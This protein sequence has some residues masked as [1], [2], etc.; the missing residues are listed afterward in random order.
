MPTTGRDSP[1]RPSIRETIAARRA[2]LR[3]TP[4]S[5]RTGDLQTYG[6]PAGRRAGTPRGFVYLDG[7]GVDQINDKSVAGQI[8][9][10]K[11]SGKLDIAGL[12]LDRIPAKVFTELLG[13]DPKGLSNPPPPPSPK[14]TLLAPKAR[15]ASASPFATEDDFQNDALKDDVFGK[16]VEKEEVWTE[17]EA[18]LTTFRAGH[19]Q[20]LTLDKEIGMFGGLKI[21]DLC[22]NGL[23]AIP[24]SLSDLLRL[25]SLDLS[26]NKLTSIPRS[27]L[28]LP[29]LQWLDLSSNSIASLSF[30]S[31]IGPSEDGLGYGQGFFSTAISRAASVKTERPVLPALHHLDLGNNKLSIEGLRALAQIKLGGMRVLNLERNAIKGVVI[32]EDLGVDAKAMP[33]LSQL[34]L[35]GNTNFRGIDG[36]LASAVMVETA[37]CNL[38]Q[39][40]PA[41]SREATP[42]AEDTSFTAPESAISSP[43]KPTGPSLPVP[44]PDLTII[45][46]NTPAMT[47]DSEPLAIDFD[48]YLP[49]A[50]AGPSG[51]PLVVW[52]HGGG[53][54]QGNKENL[55]PH[56][57]RLPSHV[58]HGEDGKAD[59]SVV[60][61]S[62]NYRLAPQ[63]P[64]IDILSDVTSLLDFI[65]T[66]LNDKL[67]KEGQSEHKVDVERICLS[68]GSAGGY[69]ALMAGLE[70]PKEVS[71]EEAGGFRG[72]SKGIKC[73]APFYPITDLT[74]KF[75]STET[76]PVPWMDG[77]IITHPQ[78]KPHIDT[79]AAH[80]CTA[81]SGGPRSI[82]YP[83][84]LQH[85]LFPS[86]LFRT[87]RAIGNGY[88]SFRPTPLA[89]SVTNRLELTAKSSR[90]QPH[91]PIYFIYGTL[92]DKVQPM[93][94]TLEVLN[95]VE[96]ELVVER[97]EGGD[98]MYDEDPAVE[99]EALREWLGKT[100]L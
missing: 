79:K 31:P 87:Q 39:H 40:T 67:V 11:K 45:Y 34:V 56:F 80:I 5:Q 63:V 41:F 3:K 60:V 100:L 4:R 28:L 8:R 37:G 62:P 49:T 72:G 25:T 36:E 38:R 76:I 66:K 17:P 59:E 46:K 15:P 93:D 73:L 47:F 21:L 26:H 22:R 91:V 51:H 82:L 18:E 12:E 69:L 97:I 20:I 50:P 81:A 94:H 99:C 42:A 43:K 86:L 90:A 32:A 65:R 52:F 35:S 27:V 77:T 68:G 44:E 7:N 57:R 30:D 19:N 88:D 55:P 14:P 6:S 96:G 29:K 83:Y 70:V 74:D 54:L 92:D 13:L 75:W 33:E 48:I 53:L 24:D 64:I 89:L 95:K 78:A 84:M 23:T 71:D 1:A 10:A 16:P 9:K 58:Y 2:E 85:S 98:H 61:I